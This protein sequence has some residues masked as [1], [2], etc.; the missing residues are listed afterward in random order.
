MTK[1]AFITG[2]TGQDGAYLS[3]LLLEKG[4]DVHGLARHADKSHCWR[5]CA[6]EIEDEVQIVE[7]DI[8]NQNMMETV[9][10][11]LQPDEIYNLA[12]Q[13][14]SADVSWEKPELTKE[15]NTNGPTYILHA[16][17]QYCAHTRFF[18]ASSS[19]IYGKAAKAT[20]SEKT[21]FHP[22]NPYA[23]SKLETHELVHTYREHHG[24][25]ACS[26]ILFN[27]ES[28][29]RGMQYVTRKITDGVAR[30]HCK[31][32]DSITLG[33]LDAKRD[34]GFA[35]DYVDAMWRMLQQDTPDDFVIA[36]GT[37]H[38]IRDMLHIAFAHIGIEQWETYIQQDE[39][40]MRPSDLPPL[41]GDATK[42]KET[43]DWKPTVSFEQMVTMMVDAD[44]NCLQQ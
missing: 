12:A 22:N 29:L 4:Y 27:H 25:F 2:I 8:T 11:D 5:L 43:L 9:I 16:I 36:T 23:K 38:S 24:I 15:T 18:Q 33:N 20:Q 40:F 31:L 30:I 21:A 3:K 32:A 10:Q 14:V 41:C 26:G 6:L 1:S 44:I 17:Q 42:A 34:W 39:R 19:E 37:L 35:G 28:P 13:S 7:G